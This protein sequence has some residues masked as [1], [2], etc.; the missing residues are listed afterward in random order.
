MTFKTAALCISTLILCVLS[1]AACNEETTSEDPTLQALLGEWCQTWP[2]D[3]RYCYSFSKNGVAEFIVY[4][5]NSDDVFSGTY[6]LNEADS[7]LEISVSIT[8]DEGDSFSIDGVYSY[9][10][11]GDQLFITANRNRFF[12]RQSGS[13]DEGV[14]RSWA[15]E[16]HHENDAFVY[17]MT[18]SNELTIAGSDLDYNFDYTR[19]LEGE[20]DIEIHPSIKGTVEKEESSFILSVT[21]ADEDGQSILEDSEKLVFCSFDNANIMITYWGDESSCGELDFDRLIYTRHSAD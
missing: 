15:S 9:A 11:V 3:R 19:Y 1:V 8:D 20:D 17:Q 18:Y 4:E 14:W 12:F 10:V 2:E 13:G 5:P 6:Q 7:K 21:S 16:E